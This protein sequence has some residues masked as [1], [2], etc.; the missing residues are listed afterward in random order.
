M[1]IIDKLSKVQDSTSGITPTGVS[2]GEEAKE[3]TRFILWR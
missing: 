1:S 3:K 2:K